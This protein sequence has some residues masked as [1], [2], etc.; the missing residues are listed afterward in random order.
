MKNN[1]LGWKKYMIFFATCFLSVICCKLFGILEA[2]L[3]AVTANA[4]YKSAA[5]KHPGNK[6]PIFA[7]GTAGLATALVSAVIFAVI[8]EMVGGAM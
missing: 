5:K 8:I 3:G 1:S 7:A 4:V 2:V 6:W